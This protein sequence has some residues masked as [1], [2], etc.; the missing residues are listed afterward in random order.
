MA[1]MSDTLS[2]PSTSDTDTWNID[3]GNA[4]GFA[5]GTFVRSTIIENLNFNFLNQPAA[6][7]RVD[8]VATGAKKITTSGTLTGQATVLN[9]AAS[10]AT[11]F[12]ASLL[13]S[14]GSRDDSGAS[15]GVGSHRTGQRWSW[16][17][18]L[19]LQQSW[20]GFCQCGCGLYN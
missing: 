16:F 15:A 17:R 4:A 7:F 19:R 13:T 9:F 11:T 3:Q 6:T 2:D 10:G 14:P 18:Y 12:D 1:N 5:T 20:F 8:Q